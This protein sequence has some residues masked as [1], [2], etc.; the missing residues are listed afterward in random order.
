MEDNNVGDDARHVTLCIKK[1]LK[2][3]LESGRF[4]TVRETGKG[5]GRFK[6]N[7]ATRRT[8]PKRK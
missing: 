1:A 2:K 6:L 7:R 5:A 8:T 4:K 3:G